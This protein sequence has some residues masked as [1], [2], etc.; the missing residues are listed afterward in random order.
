MLEH[1]VSDI[2]FII[3][4]FI[5]DDLVTRCGTDPIS[6]SQHT[7][8]ARLS[9]LKRA[10]DFERAVEIASNGVARLIHSLYTKVAPS[11][12]D[13]WG[14][15]STV[16]AVRLLCPDKDIPILRLFAVHKQLMHQHEEFVA[17]PTSHLREHVFTVRPRS[18]VE[19]IRTVKRWVREK[20]SPFPGFVRK[21]KGLIAQSRRIKNRENGGPTK[22]KDV[23]ITFTNA[24][25]QIIKFMQQHL[26]NA[27]F[28]Q[29]DPYLSL[30]PTIVKAIDPTIDEIDTE[31]IQKLLIDIGVYTPWQDV[32]VTNSQLLE[33]RTAKFS[34][35]TRGDL[36]VL[37][38][39]YPLLISDPCS[40][41]RRDFG[42]LP[43]YVIDDASAEELDDGVS[44]EPIPGESGSSRVH[45]H[46]ADPTSLIAPDSDLAKSLRK[47]MSSLYFLHDS[48][49][50]LPSSLRIPDLN[51]KR[52]DPDEGRNVM[53]FSFT[54]DEKGNLSDPS[55]CAGTIRNVHTATYD[56]VDS[57]LGLDPGRF[58]SYPFNPSPHD[59]STSKTDMSY[60]QPHE[61]NIRRLHKVAQS[62]VQNR[63][64]QPIFSFTLPSAQVT[65]T[66]RPCPSH[67]PS[68]N[69][70]TFY[71][72]FP[73]LSYSVLDHQKQDTG[74]R[75]LVSELM[76]AACRVSSLFCTEHGVPA[77][78][79]A[80]EPW[81][82]S[83]D[84][85]LKQLLSQRS[86]NGY[87]NALDVLKAGYF[88]QPS[89]YT[90]EPA[91]HWVMGIKDG[92]GYVRSTSPLRRFPDMVTHWQIK[93]ALNQEKPPFSVEDLQGLIKELD[94][95]EAEYK[96]TSRT[97]ERY[98]PLMFIRRFMEQNASDRTSGR[99]DPLR[100]IPA[101]VVHG[102]TK[103]IVLHM[104]QTD[105]F[106]PS[107][108]LLAE[109]H[110]EK[111]TNWSVA[112]QV[113]INVQNIRLGRSPRFT[114]ELA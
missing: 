22:L 13:A 9:A 49:P 82:I 2:V 102:T 55:V 96:R 73:T 83:S 31:V 62:L 70:P 77:I 26:R 60:L 43:V 66:P 79:R 106:I 76:K 85:E 84:A 46:I 56:D 18:H 75:S 111:N 107:L 57:L 20:A 94:Q 12:L 6:T 114:V 30:M 101:F 63:L 33:G 109:L 38:E 16:E 68:T 14:Q 108:G 45:V 19:N 5:E 48:W 105:V 3:P 113:M 69:K 41:I 88:A 29:T 32:T 97:H 112:D 103:N 52:I 28:I 36:N 23:P 64:T 35:S 104:Y 4:R 39:Q 95:F 90:V 80:A 24:E 10:K 61:A 91:R 87:V 92:E 100:N 27:R 7:T 47:N 98:W 51:N 86:D 65:I 42:N 1:R 54:V 34:E 110:T 8:A 59:V 17:H 72:G 89:R 21:A 25:M 71:S 78:R 74:S 11:D 53:T 15:V 40:S 99:R 67:P 81:E 44:F 58:L 93:A 50:M 37:V